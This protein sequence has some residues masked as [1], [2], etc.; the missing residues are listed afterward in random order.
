M[1]DKIVTVSSYGLFCLS[2]DSFNGFLR[3]HK[4]KSK[5]LAT[6]FNKN[7][8]ILENALQVGCLLPVSI[9]NSIDYKI[10]VSE[11]SNLFDEA[12]DEVLTIHDCNL[13]VGEDATVWVGSM[14]VLDEWNAENYKDK[15]S[16]SYQTL[17]NETLFKAISFSVSP[18]SY[19]VTLHGF[20]RHETASFPI[21]NFGFAFELRPTD[22]FES[23]TNLLELDVN[24]AKMK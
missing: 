17:D 18:G 2:V 7:R 20:K 1:K 3:E 10:Q 9:I 16:I 6:F 13:L 19:K 22:N 23:F 4:I 8:P 14:G 5:K 12:W 11:E 15:K 21:A 24:I